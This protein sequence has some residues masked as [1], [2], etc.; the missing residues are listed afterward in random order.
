MNISKIRIRNFRA[1]KD[2]EIPLES[3]T[4]LIGENNAGKS[5]VLDC[6]SLALNRGRGQIGSRFSENDLSLLL[7]EYGSDDANTDKNHDPDSSLS[8]IDS[9]MSIGPGT[10]ENLPETTIELFFTE[11]SVNQ[12]SDEV[13]IG[14]SG[15]IQIDPITELNSITLQVSYKKNPVENEYESAWAFLNIQ[16]EPIETREAKRAGTS[17][18]FFQLV[19]VFPLSALRDS[20]EEFSSRSQFWGRLL[21]AIE[22]SPDERQ[23][24]DEAIEELNTGLLSADPRV[25]DTVDTLKEIQN[26]IA[27][28]AV[29]D[30]SIR[31]LP[32]RIWELLTRS[33]IVV[34]GESSAPWL[35]LNRQGQGIKSLSVIYLFKA[36]VARLLNEKYSKLSQPIVTLEEPEVHLHPQAVRA[37]WSQ[38]AALPG[39]KI[40]STHS[41]YFTQHVPIGNVRLL[42][43]TP[44]GIKAFYVQNSVS[45]ALPPNEAIEA[46]TSNN[47]QL[48]YNA[49]TSSLC[50]SRRIDE[51][52]CRKIMRCYPSPNNKEII[53]SIHQFRT[54]SLEL[55]EESDLE[56]LED[57]ARRIR[58]EVFFSSA[59]LLC[60]GQSEVFLLTALFD[61]LGLNLDTYGVSLIDYKN[62]GNPRA[63]ACLARTFGFPW[64]LLADGDLEGNRTMRSLVNAGFTSEELSASTVQLPCG[65]DIE[66]LV[67]S[68]VWR[69]VAIDV[70]REFKGELLNENDDFVLAE[71]LRAHKP[72]WAR[73]LGIRLKKEP[74]IVDSIPDELACLHAMIVR[75]V[76]PK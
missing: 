35:P 74:S 60:E 42:R 71:A 14:L 37:L 67:V 26:V 1:F 8:N 66:K 72:L 22:I 3:S 24:L 31:A 6:I 18:Q 5:S 33:E 16:G 4:V 49:R 9:E 53:Q 68:S 19:P 55:I 69:T 65:F 56:A 62:N 38:I 40:I 52:L 57:W 75:L 47:D 7:D 61:A 70:A 44:D 28:G 39:Q 20:S 21:R 29:A 45:V 43:R 73:R 41:P 17:N 63:F 12:W 51:Q 27:N 58:G 46:L 15:I 76:T 59:W 30:V 48:S 32:T 23:N 2:V 64:V 11:N 34:K 50:S 54:H 36:F 25:Y 13:T 10:D